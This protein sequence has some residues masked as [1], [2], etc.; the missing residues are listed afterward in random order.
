MGKHTKSKDQS[1]ETKPT[2]QANDLNEMTKKA[3]AEQTNTPAEAETAMNEVLQQKCNELNDKYLRLYSEFDN[4]RKRVIKEKI[5]L[6]KTASE[7][8]ITGLL[9]VLDDFERALQILPVDDNDPNKQGISLIFNKLKTI[10]SQKG[11]SE[12]K[13]LEEKFDTDFHEAI[14]NIPAPSEELKNKI[15]DVTQKGYMLNGKVIRF[16][17]VVVGI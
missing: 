8:V 13:S 11:L 10:L 15:V 2:D 7:D 17:K 1:K 5:E 9:T 12:I 4:Y 3:T 14:A 6:S 16:A